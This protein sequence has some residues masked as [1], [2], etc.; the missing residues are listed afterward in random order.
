[1]RSLIGWA[2]ATLLFAGMPHGGSAQLMFGGFV[3]SQDGITLEAAGTEEAP[4][5][6]TSAQLDSALVAR[7]IERVVLRQVCVPDPFRF[8]GREI[9]KELVFDSVTFM[10]FVRLNRTRF[11]KA[12]S[13]LNSKFRGRVEFNG[14]VFDSAADF[15]GVTFEEDVFSSFAEFGKGACFTDAGFRRTANFSR[16]TFT[17]RACFYRTFFEGPASCPRVVFE[18]DAIF[19][20]AHFEG[21]ADF[22]RGI[23]GGTVTYDSIW[24]VPVHL[25]SAQ[26]AFVLSKADSVRDSARDS[27]L[28]LLRNANLASA[29]ESSAG[30]VANFDSTEFNQGV[31]L[32]SAT[33]WGATD[34]RH[35]VFG[36]AADFSKAVF[37]WTPKFSATT[38]SKDASFSGARYREGAGF[39]GGS[40]ARRSHL[41]WI[42]VAALLALL[43]FIVLQFKKIYGMGFKRVAVNEVFLA[44][45]VTSSLLIF[46]H[47]VWRTA[48]NTYVLGSFFSSLVA[49][50]A[51]VLLGTYAVVF[52][53]K[54]RQVEAIQ[55][56]LKREAVEFRIEQARRV[57]EGLI[58]LPKGPF[59]RP[60][61]RLAHR[62]LPAEDIAADFYNL[63]PRENGSLGIYLVDVAGHG[64]AAAQHAQAIHQA[65]RRS[66]TEWGR[67]QASGELDL[68]DRLI[69]DELGDQNIAAS[70]NFTEIHPNSMRVRHANAGMPSP[71]LFRYGHAQPEPLLASGTFVGAGYSRYPVKP[72]QAEVSVGDG[73]LLLIFSDGVTEAK[74]SRGRLFGQQGIVAAVSRSRLESPE[75][76]VDEILAAVRQHTGRKTAEPDDIVLIAVKIGKTVLGSRAPGVRTLVQLEGAPEVLEFELRNAA[77]AADAC[78]RELKGQVMSWAQSRGTNEARARQ[79]WAATWEAMLNALRH[80]ST[81][82]DFIN[83]TLRVGKQGMLEVEIRQPRIWPEWD[84]VL[85]AWG[86]A[87][88]Q[89]KNAG[90]FLGGA[91][92]ML[93]LATQISVAN[94]GRQVLMRFQAE[95]SSSKTQ[96]GK[97]R[98]G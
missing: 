57:V 32:S 52:V 38:F 91:V 3:L 81:L 18:K 2:V 78:D 30:R 69:S 70:M 66:G 62:Y 72:R 5:T 60:G 84:T 73:D 40:F 86:K 45:T 9:H 48:G 1:M 50:M 97:S 87:R 74:D 23:F 79:I 36:G 33:F 37:A 68:A 31:S 75:S 19:T 90:I 12:V 47:Y 76:I 16:A 44:L 92:I 85:G 55:E 94:R 77:D 80:G 29:A 22:S 83:V 11:R 49:A 56:R 51:I 53:Q 93:K 17:D 64:L 27:L 39:I 71:L 88:I 10:S 82:G 65:V 34:F 14:A 95:D 89:E 24:T 58:E 28:E 21:P 67:G 20:N 13:F 8:D 26:T 59:V 42:S 46:V 15:M 61:I 98:N 54:R 35:A 96:G 4:D 63:I 41:I 43:R 6:I 25:D 7:H